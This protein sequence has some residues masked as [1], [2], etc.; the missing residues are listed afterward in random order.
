MRSL[1]QCVAERGI[2]GLALCYAESDCEIGDERRV[3][4]GIL[5]TEIKR[6]TEIKS[7]IARCERAKGGLTRLPHVV[8]RLFQVG[9][10]HSKRP[11]ARKF[12]DT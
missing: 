8:D 6:L 2:S 10:L 5:V 7:R 4:I 1:Q 9:W 3:D 11:V 12:P